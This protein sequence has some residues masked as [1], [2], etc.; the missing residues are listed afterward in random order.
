MFQLIAIKH[1]DKY[2]FQ[3]RTKHPTINAFLVADV[4]KLL[5]AVE[6]YQSHKGKPQKNLRE[7]LDEF[8]VLAIIMYALILLDSAADLAALS[9][10]KKTIETNEQI[11]VISK[12]HRLV[13]LDDSGNL[14]LEN[15]KQQESDCLEHLLKVLKLENDLGNL[16]EQPESNCCKHLPNVLKLIVSE[17]KQP[18]DKRKPIFDYLVYYNLACYHAL[19]ARKKSELFKINR[20]DLLDETNAMFRYLQYALKQNKSLKKWAA[21]DPSFSWVQAEKDTLGNKFREI[22][23]R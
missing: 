5:K 8:E 4:T 6:Y 3:D 18:E 9:K 12:K 14:S 17:N 22:I 21:I 1:Y 23:N 7:F 20:D 2:L 15:E 13:S 11:K 10:A 19:C 16:P